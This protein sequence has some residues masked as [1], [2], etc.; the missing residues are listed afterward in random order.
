MS[1][2]RVQY[3]ASS[4]SLPT[5]HAFQI[6]SSTFQERSKAK[7][8]KDW[9]AAAVRASPGAPTGGAATSTETAQAMHSADLQHRVDW[10]IRYSATHS[11]QCIR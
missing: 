6:L 8:P 1:S 7:G 2:G 10:Q 3:S 4:V 9:H 5:W 11:V